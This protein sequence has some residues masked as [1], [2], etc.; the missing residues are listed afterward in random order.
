AAVTAAAPTLPGAAIVVKPGEG[1]KEVV[2]AFQ[3]VLINDALQRH[4]G[5]WAE[6]AR[7]LSLDRA[8]LSRLAKRLGIR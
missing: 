7:E 6:V 1:L 3:T 8:N 2:D 4:Q 5:R